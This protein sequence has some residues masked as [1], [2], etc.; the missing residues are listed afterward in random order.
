MYSKILKLFFR[1]Y[2]L[3]ETRRILRNRY[4]GGTMHGFDSFLFTG[5]PAHGQRLYELLK[6]RLL[7]QQQQRRQSITTTTPTST[8][9]TTPPPYA[10]DLDI[11]LEEP[12]C[13]AVIL[14]LLYLHETYGIPRYVRMA[15]ELF[16]EMKRIP[17]L[18]STL[19]YNV[20]VNHHRVV[21]RLAAQGGG[22]GGA[23]GLRIDAEVAESEGKV[24][25]LFQEMQQQQQQHQEQCLPNA[26]T[27]DLM[28]D[29]HRKNPRTVLSLASLARSSSTATSTTTTHL[30]HHYPPP[31][32]PPT[33]LPPQ[34]YANLVRIFDEARLY[35]KID[36]TV[37]WMKEDGVEWDYS[38][39]YALITSYLG[40]GLVQLA[41]DSLIMSSS[42]TIGKK[43]DTSYLQELV[44]DAKMKFF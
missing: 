34:F 19:T 12:A 30:P 13:C 28:I 31:P 11:P 3:E 38:F 1:Y 17:G 20:F 5:N 29:Y 37:S 4:G 15:E 33:P 21:A 14:S 41:E 16:A 25:F 10:P 35:S 23:K 39:H 8:T 6:P 24:D 26:I 42:A 27:Y 2:Y 7:N 43:Y 44:E 40:R 22:V 9:T 36:E 18:V 32:P